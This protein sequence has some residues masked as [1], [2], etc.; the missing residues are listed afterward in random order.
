[1]KR[2]YLKLICYCNF[3]GKLHKH[4]W[5]QSIMTDEN[6]DLNQ[7]I[8]FLGSKCITIAYIYYFKKSYTNMFL[9]S[10]YAYMPN[11]ILIGWLI[12]ELFNFI[13]IVTMGLHDL[14]SSWVISWS[15]LFLDLL[16]NMSTNYCELIQWIITQETV[17]IAN[18]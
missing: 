10:K 18:H 9:Q 3:K 17:N 16:K 2:S 7:L 12:R 6:H 4:D 14:M 11:F 1:M 15:K 13:Q 5:C 8:W